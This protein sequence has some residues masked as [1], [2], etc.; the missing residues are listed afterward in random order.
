MHERERPVEQMIERR[1]DIPLAAPKKQE[2]RIHSKKSML[3]PEEMVQPLHI[4]GSFR[5]HMKKEQQRKKT[6]FL[7]KK[8]LNTKSY[9]DAPPTTSPAFG[10][11]L[12]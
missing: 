12:Q 11:L 7:S 8:T 5:P 2:E 6:S 1:S 3:T 9:L 4:G 10:R